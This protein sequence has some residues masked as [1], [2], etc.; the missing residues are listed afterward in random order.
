MID[1]QAYI[2]SGVLELYVY[3]TLS[4]AESLE[5]SRLVALHPELKAEVEQI[6]A[7]LQQLAS[8]A[9]PYT[10]SNFESIQAKIQSKEG[11]GVIPLSRKRIPAAT[12]LGWAA[13]VLLLVAVG[14]QFTEKQKLE[15]KITTIEREQI[16]QEGKILI[17]E[18][19]LQ[20]TKALL[21]VL[22]D[23][24]VIAVP[25]GAQAI[26]PE[27]YASIYWD[28]ETGKAYVDVRGLPT[29]PKGKVYQLWSLTLDPL[30]PT[31]M[32]V[33]NQ[34]DTDGTQLFEIENPNASEAF[35]ITLE[36]EGGSASPTLEQLYVLGVVEP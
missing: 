31:S 8:A 16:L 7:A 14:Y 18:E 17:A 25:L 28:K 11:D 29:P 4:E 26:A 27:A 36:P 1:I 9:A 32:A 6:E 24:D 34:Y 30:T 13:A 33:L 5:V 12:Y 21:D 10:P 2:D 15:E 3:G 22:R 20:K 35:G 19:D 23:K